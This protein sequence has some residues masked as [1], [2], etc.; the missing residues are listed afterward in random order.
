MAPQIA[1]LVATS[2]TSVTSLTSLTSLILLLFI[3]ILQQPTSLALVVS[4]TPALWVHST[5]GANTRRD[6][7]MRVGPHPTH[8]SRLL[9]GGAYSPPAP[10]AGESE[11]ERRVMNALDAKRRAYEVKERE[12]T[13]IADHP[14]ALRMTYMATTQNLKLYE[15][16]RLDKGDKRA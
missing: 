12:V 1:V 13:Q 7:Q 5:W 6:G 10:L 8:L 11:Y 9:S 15:S 4:N 16:V 14:L 2:L 3:S